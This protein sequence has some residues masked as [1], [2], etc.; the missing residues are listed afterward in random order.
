LNSWV[1]EM[2]LEELE[3][4]RVMPLVCLLPPAS[5]MFPSELSEARL[6]YAMENILVTV[7]D[8]MFDVGGSKEELDN[9]ITLIDK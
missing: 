2:R 7:V 9:F 6:A 4:A 5:T 3:F 1:K 8:D